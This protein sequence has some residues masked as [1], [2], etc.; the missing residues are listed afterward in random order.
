[1]QCIVIMLLIDINNYYL[2]DAGYTN[3]ECF[4]APYRGQIYHLN[5]WSEHHQPTTAQEYFNMK[6]SQARNCIERCFGILKARCAILREKL[7]YPCKTQWRIISACCLLYNFIRT[8]MPIDPIKESVCDVS[9]SQPMGDDEEKNLN[10][11]L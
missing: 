5:D 3:G 10:Q 1:M 6:H 9:S 4:L 7:F 2:C 8:E 11:A